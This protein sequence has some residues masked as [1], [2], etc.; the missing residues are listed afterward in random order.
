MQTDR[1]D[2]AV[3][4]VY[5]GI[6]ETDRVLARF[7]VRNHTKLQAVTTTRN[8]LLVKF[9]AEP[10]AQVGSHFSFLF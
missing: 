8:T 5:D 6:S 10:K 9:M 2:S 7:S 1:N 3:I 4:V